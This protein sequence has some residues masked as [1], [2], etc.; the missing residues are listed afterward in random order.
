MKSNLFVAL[1]LATIL[2]G[3]EARKET[4]TSFVKIRGNHFELNGKPYYFLGTNFWYGLNLGSKGEGGN[5]ER[6]I[7]ELDRLNEMG[8]KNLRIMA[9]SEGPDNAPFRMLPA[10]QT[11]PGVY[12][13]DVLEGLD[14]LLDEMRKRDMKAVM[15]LNNFWNWSGGVGQYLVWSGAAD[16]IPHPPPQPGGDWDRYQKFAATFYSAPKAVELFNKHIEF[17]VNRKNGLSGVNYKDDPAIM[18]WE[19]GNEPRGI[20]NIEPYL[21][22]IDETAGL[23]KKHDPNHLVTTGSEG[24]TGSPQYS[25][26]DLEKDHSSDNIDYTTIHIWVQNWNIYNPTKADS[27][28]EPSI[29]YALNYLNEHVKIA[30]K[31][32]KPIVLEEFG[33]SRDLNN[34]DPS[35]PVVIRDKYYSKLFEGVLNNAKSPNSSLAG[36]NF[37]AWGGEGRPRVPEGMWKLNDDFIGDPPHESQGWYSIYDTDSTTIKIIKD[38]ASKISSIGQ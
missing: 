8:V 20:N 28:Y 25:G 31:L 1:I 5:R 38:Y 7:R 24:A 4:P 32:N 29:Q 13:S 10:L 3:C 11:S 9:G 27:T 15:C 30:N 2:L 22:W 6:L 19:L 37:W 35:S 18:A 14:F 33:I 36:C 12:N 17:I 21:K 26:T 34:H 16:S 23:I